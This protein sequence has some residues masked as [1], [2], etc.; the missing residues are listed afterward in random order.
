MDQ[1]SPKGEMTWLTPR[2][3]IL[4]NFIALRQRM[5]EISVTKIPADKRKNKKTSTPV[6]RTG[7]YPHMT[8]ADRRSPITTKHKEFTTPAVTDHAAEC[9]SQHTRSVTVV[10]VCRAGMTSV[11]RVIDFSI[12]DLGG[13]TPRLKV[14]KRGD[15]LLST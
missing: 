13:L 9:F 14:T 12:F 7:V 6:V 10:Q 4:Q 15:D 2:S 1:S 11:E 3:T 8:I 5:P